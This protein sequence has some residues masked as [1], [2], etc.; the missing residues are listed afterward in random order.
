MPLRRARDTAAAAAEEQEEEEEEVEEM[1]A[2]TVFFQESFIRRADDAT[3]TTTT[4][5][6]NWMLGRTERKKGGFWQMSS[7]SGLTRRWHHRVYE[8]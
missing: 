6:W 7:F 4:K 8:L 5:Y 1:K 2:E 3:T